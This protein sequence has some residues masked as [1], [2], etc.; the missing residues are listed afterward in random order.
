MYDGP[1]FE[2][3]PDKGPVFTFGLRNRSLQEKTAVKLIC[4]VEAKPP[5]KVNYTCSVEA[6]SLFHR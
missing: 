5:P 6:Y 2:E 4:S 1:E 3:E